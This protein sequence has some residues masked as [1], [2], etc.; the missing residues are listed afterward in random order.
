MCQ[1]VWHCLFQPHEILHR[2]TTSVYIHIKL[3]IL[4]LLFIY[5]G[6]VSGS[7]DHHKTEQIFGALQTSSSFFKFLPS[8][9]KLALMFLMSRP[10]K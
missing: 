9:M 7:S 5:T 2:D 4:L 3:Y 10:M 8:E 1:N 6:N